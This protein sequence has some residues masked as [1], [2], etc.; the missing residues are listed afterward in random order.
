[1][2]VEHL[3]RDVHDPSTRT[4]GGMVKA[5]LDGLDSLAGRLRV[6][7][8]YLRER[9]DDEKMD[10][11]DS[12]NGND[13]RNTIASGS[14]AGAGT[15]GRKPNS[16]IVSNAQTILGLLPTSTPGICLCRYCARLTMITW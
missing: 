3:L 1:M 4:V 7:A 6:I 5:R 15:G 12:S 11:V 2:G 10:I 8:S 14:G 16:E 9:S 13:E